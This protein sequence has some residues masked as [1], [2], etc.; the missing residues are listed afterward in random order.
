MHESTPGSDAREVTSIGEV[1]RERALALAERARLREQQT[2]S[3]P[4]ASASP[5]GE[6]W[7][8]E[9][10]LRLGGVP[11]VYREA[12]W[13]TVRSGAVREWAYGVGARTAKR[14]DPGSPNHA[15]L[16]VGLLILGPTGTG[17]SSA[18][19]LC[20]RAAAEAERTVRWTYLPDLVDRMTA[21]AKERQH[22]IAMQVGVD[23]LVWDDLGVRDLADWEIGY[24]DQIVEGRYRRRR[25]MVVTSNWTP[26]DLKNDQRLGRL[27]DRWR[28]RTARDL[29][30]LGGPSM[31]G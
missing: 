6:A 27:V 9:R 15:L 20:C 12:K 31:R 7:R 21:G 14:S 5:A 13:P 24:L 2:P 8:V 18:A 29:V 25:P 26:E 4:P 16:G 19:A 22:E 10:A 1:M 11:D 28:D 30:V 17:K 23:L 3:A